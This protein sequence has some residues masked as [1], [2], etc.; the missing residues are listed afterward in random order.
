VLFDADRKSQQR[1]G[2][3]FLFERWLARLVDALAGSEI[4]VIDHRLNGRNAP[5]IDLRS[6]DAGS[7]DATTGRNDGPA[8]DDHEFTAPNPP[9]GSGS[10]Q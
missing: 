9:S 4:I 1:D 3:A 10:K 7:R 6:F 8:D 2:D 5:T